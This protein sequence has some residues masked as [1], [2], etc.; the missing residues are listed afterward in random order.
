MFG[1][2]L[3]RLGLGISKRL[4]SDLCKK[5]PDD[6]KD[7]VC[8]DLEKK[9]ALGQRLGKRT[10]FF[11]RSRADVLALRAQEKLGTR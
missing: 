11:E 1:F 6:F 2:C 5:P 7:E 3:A 4:V 10:A 8:S 9:L